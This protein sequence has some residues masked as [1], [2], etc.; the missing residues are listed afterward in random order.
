[1]PAGAPQHAM[2]E[3]RN[4][5]LRGLAAICTLLVPALA[6]GAPVAPAAGSEDSFTLTVENDLLA[7][8]DSGYTSGVGATWTH[9]GLASFMDDR[10]PGW[11]QAISSRLYI[12]RLP[13]T[14]RA[15]SYTL[16][17][18]MQT[19]KDL[20]A[21]QRLDGQLPYAGLLAWS[22]RLHAWNARG[23]DTAALTLGVV[24]PLSGA[25]QTQK[26]VHRLT[27]STRPEG[28]RNQIGD[29]PV[30][31]LEAQRLRRLAGGDEGDGPGWD[32]VGF[33]LLGLGT[34]R[35]YGAAGAGFRFGY[36]LDRGYPDVTVLPGLQ[37]NPLAGTARRS[38]Y[39]FLAV[40]GAF[41]ANDIGIERG[42][43]TP[44]RLAHWQRQIAAGLTVNR[45]HW[46][47]LLSMVR[48]SDRYV[49]Q[50]DSTRYG[51]LSVTYRY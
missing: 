10:V 2:V 1:M 12:S 9:A 6:V 19:P 17:Q 38:S 5:T 27:G 31:L 13:D 49:G 20:T 41:V 26:F 14:M 22:A 45:D 3:D 35:S 34:I 46:A 36:G 24:G 11:L 48:A 33:G 16:G 44:L 50:S 15:V 32:T 4:L 43:G 18:L 25:E 47:F 39:V 28:W 30:F 40:L 21:T 37:V 29:E 42:H 7:G 8:K 23:T 51:S